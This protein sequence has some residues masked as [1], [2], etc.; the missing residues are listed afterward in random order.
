MEGLNMNATTTSALKGLTFIDAPPKTDDPVVR[1]RNHVVERLEEQLRM[2]EDPKYVRTEVKFRGKG[3]SR[4]QVTQQKKV[5]PWFRVTPTGAAMS[6]MV[7]AKPLEFEKGK[8]A[9]AVSKRDEL[10][11]VVKALVQ[12]V[13]NGELDRQLTAAHARVRPVGRKAQGAPAAA[14]AARK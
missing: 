6:I 13:I 9:V 5:R 2:I 10:P 8:H 7:G 14:S 1:R 4:R 11:D 12:A 3:E